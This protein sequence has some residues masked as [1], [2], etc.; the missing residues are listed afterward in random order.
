MKKEWSD[1]K[2]LT[3][4]C[5]I[6]A[7]SIIVYYFL[8]L[9]PFLSNIGVSAEEVLKRENAFFPFPPTSLADIKWY[10]DTFFATF[11]FAEP[12]DFNQSLMLTGITALFFLAGC[13]SMYSRSREKLIILIAPVLF[14]LIAAAMHQ[15]PFKGRL[16]LFL[17]PLFLIIIAEG[18][19]F[20]YYNLRNSSKIIFAVIIVFLFIYPA[21]WAAY[22]AKKP[23]S[24]GRT[25]PVLQYINDNW[26]KGDILY[27]HFYAQYEFDYY[28]KYHMEPFVFNEDEY[29]IGI[30][31]RNWYNLWKRQDVS[32]YYD[33]TATS[34]QSNSD[35]LKEYIKDIDKLTGRNRVWMLF[36][37]YV[38]STKGLKDNSFFLFHLDTKGTRLDSFSNGLAS[39]YLYN[40]NNPSNTGHDR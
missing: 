39:V 37:T 21:S 22:H 38:S 7:L 34:K 11:N 3:V 29:I 12:H 27:V 23:L 19:E 1:I 28:T 4:V 6:W 2:G 17:T 20:M 24:T 33:T 35:I 31:P 5:S 8:Y 16:I 15:Y 10:I 26:Q 36:V 32:K 13:I 30:A 9:E 40:L 25:R 14:T 18:I